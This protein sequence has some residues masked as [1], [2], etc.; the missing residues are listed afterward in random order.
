MPH[1]FLDLFHPLYLA[2]FFQLN[3][4]CHPGT[5]HFRVDLTEA[6]LANA[7]AGAMA[8][9]LGTFGLKRIVGN[10]GPF[11]DPAGLLCAVVFSRN[12]YAC[13]HAGSS[14]DRFCGI[15]NLSL[16]WTA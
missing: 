2:D 7:S 14:L 10:R 6:S 8:H 3:I 9:E 12:N 11:M 16:T 5:G 15:G 4:E 13:G 1:I